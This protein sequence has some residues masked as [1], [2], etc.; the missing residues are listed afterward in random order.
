MNTK[1]KLFIDTEKKSDE[2][3]RWYKDKKIKT[4]DV[5]ILKQMYSDFQYKE[6]LK[7]NPPK[8][9]FGLYDLPCCDWL[10]YL[11]LNF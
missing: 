2:F 6:L 4:K 7:L 5:E 9:L 10:S 1:R 3:L 11:D 8:K